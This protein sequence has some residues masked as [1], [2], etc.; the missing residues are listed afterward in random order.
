MSRSPTE[1]SI[2]DFL[3]KSYLIP[4][5]HG[6]VARYFQ[7]KGGESNSLFGLILFWNTCK[8]PNIK[9][10]EIPS[11]F[12]QHNKDIKRKQKFPC[13]KESRTHSLVFVPLEKLRICLNLEGCRARARARGQGQMEKMEQ[14]VSILAIFEMDCALRVEEK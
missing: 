12:R 11:Y 10:G 14:N 1:K 5:E 8:G 13:K 3:L 6:P 9:R 7:E 4:R 2:S